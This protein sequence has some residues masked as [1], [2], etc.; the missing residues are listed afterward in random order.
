MRTL[1]EAVRDYYTERSYNCSEAILHA[2]NECYGLN[3]REE[4]MK[5]MGG[6]GGGMHAGLVCGAL[7]AA[8][9]ALSKMIVVH[10]AREE[11]DTVRPAVSRLVRTFN[12]HLGGL[13]CRELRPKYYTKED[14]CLQTVLLAAQALQMAVDKIRLP[15]NERA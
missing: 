13:S 11:G 1:E 14:S 8:V 7:V 6:F 12:E 9:A 4:D 5:M 15:E 2:A 10:K 3:I